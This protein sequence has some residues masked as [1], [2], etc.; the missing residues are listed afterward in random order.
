LG[1]RGCRLHQ[2]NRFFLIASLL[3]SILIPFLHFDI[4]SFSPVLSQKLA[5]VSLLVPQ[6]NTAGTAITNLSVAGKVAINW[7]TIAGLV[8][9]SC[10][11]ILLLLL[12][13]RVFA[14]GQ[15]SRQ[16]PKDPIRRNKSC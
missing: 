15:L 14:I 5:P 6:G 7:P 11:L 2:Y 13:F 9:A 4:I 3:L 1:L 16:F 10:S 12:A 8:I